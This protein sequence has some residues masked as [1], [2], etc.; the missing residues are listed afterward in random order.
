MAQ[1]IAI[2]DPHLLVGQIPAAYFLGDVFCAAMV[3]P[4]LCAKYD[5]R[6]LDGKLVIFSCFAQLPSDCESKAQYP[7]ISVQRSPIFN[8]ENIAQKAHEYG[9]SWLKDNAIVSEG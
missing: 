7:H 4:G 8:R 6:I 5:F 2:H 9:C 1:N 3:C